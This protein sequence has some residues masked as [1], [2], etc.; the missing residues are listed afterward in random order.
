MFLIKNNRYYKGQYLTRTAKCLHENFTL[1]YSNG[2][3][4]VI[5]NNTEI[6]NTCTC[7]KFYTQHI[8]CK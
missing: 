8:V 4:C 3:S 2:D 1:S 5:K 7:R 6:N